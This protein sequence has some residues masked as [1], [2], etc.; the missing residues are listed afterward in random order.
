MSVWSSGQFSSTWYGTLSALVAEGRAQVAAAAA[1]SDWSKRIRDKQYTST[2]TMKI[3]RW[4][5]RGPRG[6]RI[7]VRTCSKYACIARARP[8]HEHPERHFGG[9]RDFCANGGGQ[10]GDCEH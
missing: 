8:E 3:T 5:L 9:C 7:Y 10:P 4:A 1:N 2:L 6:V